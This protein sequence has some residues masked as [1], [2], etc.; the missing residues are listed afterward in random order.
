MV[1]EKIQY[2]KSLIQS[3]DLAL[4]RKQLRELHPRSLERRFLLPMAQLAKDCEMLHLSLSL[5]S[6]VINP[7]RPLVRGATVLEKAT[8]AA[9]LLKLGAVQESIEMLSDIS[10]Q[11]LPDTLLYLGQAH[12]HLWNYD[13]AKGLF[14]RYLATGP[15]GTKEQIISLL[16]LSACHIF[17]REYELALPLLDEVIHQSTKED[18]R[19]YLGNA[20]EL[21]GQLHYHT[22]EYHQAEKYLAQAHSLLGPTQHLS[23]L[24]VLKWKQ[25][26]AIGREG[27][28]QTNER[29][30]QEIRSFAA[31]LKHGETIRD[32]DLFLSLRKGDVE[33]L[34]KLYFGTPSEFFRKRIFLECKGALSLPETYSWRETRSTRGSLVMNPVELERHFSPTLARTILFLASDIYRFRLM[35]QLHFSVYNGEKYNPLSSPQ[36]IYQ[37]ISQLRKVAGPYFEVLGSPRQCKIV[38]KEFEFVYRRQKAESREVVHVKGT[39]IRFPKKPFQIRELLE[40]YG[41]PKRTLQRYVNEECSKGTLLKT[42]CGKG[43]LYQ[44]NSGV[45][46]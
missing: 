35:P 29:S 19:V 7:S 13:T 39:V 27:L 22:K 31:E 38:P 45:Q 9:S 16:N 23:Q 32:I 28:T 1:Q 11:D 41:L 2:I 30:L 37:L 36:K 3:G 5:L 26:V 33:T 12:M 20:Y 34:T 10:P 46:K 43:T 4:A 25:Y 17:L 15:L 40:Q 8:Y 6:P 24:F 18:R 44:M 14:T 42:G 21:L